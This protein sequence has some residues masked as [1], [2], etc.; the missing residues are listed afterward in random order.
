VSAAKTAS[1]TPPPEPV[2][3][4]QHAAAADHQPEVAAGPLDAVADAALGRREQAD[5]GRV[6]GDVMGRRE[7]RDGGA[8]PDQ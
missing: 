2:I 3:D 4:D 6:G 7:Q 8:D 1:A 5:S